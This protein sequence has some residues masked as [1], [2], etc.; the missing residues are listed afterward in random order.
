MTFQQT[1]L[2]IAVLF[3]IVLFSYEI[4]IMFRD[5]EIVILLI[6]SFVWPI[7]VPSYIAAKLGHAVR[8]RD[9]RIEQ[10]LRDQQRKEREAD[11]ALKREGV[12]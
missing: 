4:F 10:E 7:G 12:I 2:I 3:T 1:Y 5:E 6:A 11:E 9:K 8:E